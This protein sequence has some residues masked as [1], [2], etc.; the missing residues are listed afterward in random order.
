MS[1]AQIQKDCRVALTSED[2]ILDCV[3][4][5]FGNSHPRLIL[6]R[7]DDCA[8]FQGSKKFCASADLFLEDI[9]F[10][11]TYFEPGEIGHKA[12][13]VN[14]SDL[15]AC[16][17]KPVAFT[18]C[19]GLPPDLDMSWLDSFFSRMASLAAQYNMILAGGDLSR[20]EKLHISITVFGENLDGCE[21]LRRG[22][23]MPGDSIFVVG[24]IGL[25][26]VGLS[27][28]E[29]IGREAMKKWPE[30]CG[31]HLCPQPQ[32][33]AGLMLARAGNN[34]RPPALMD[35]SD[36]IL[37]DLPR[38]LGQNGE[39]GSHSKRLGADI[40]LSSACLPP[41]VVEYALEHDLDPA[42][43]ALT[44]GEDYALLGSCAPDMVGALSTAIPGFYQIGQVTDMGRIVCNG[45]DVTDLVGFDH[46]ENGSRTEA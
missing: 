13:A 18:L 27:E 24:P 1:A 46:F 3:A 35:L 22:G 44:G 38:L 7:G 12:L 2:D 21:F 39:L 15:A 8:M 42:L 26:R 11:R 6:G 10:R 4:R 28:L 5:H 37:R 43:E 40:A 29:E 25:A 33:G 14:I 32:V 9:H 45:L 19:L 20:C 41:E 31:A 34:A 23:S 36:G 16:G 30:S 17:A